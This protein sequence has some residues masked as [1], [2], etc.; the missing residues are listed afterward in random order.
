MIV[1]KYSDLQLISSFQSKR[2]NFDLNF[3]PA[4]GDL[5]IRFSLMFRA[6]EWEFSR[7][8]G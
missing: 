3:G 7:N 5:K 4:N 1:Y 2:I 8:C 6:A